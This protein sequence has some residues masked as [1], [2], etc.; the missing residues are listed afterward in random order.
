MTTPSDTQSL[1]LSRAA[2]RPGNLA[3]PLPDGLV[4]AA[5][6]MVVG[7]M[8]AR[9]WLDEVEA[10]LRRGEPMWRET[11]DGHGTTLIATEA[12]LEAI[13]IEPMVANAVANV[14]KAKPK[15][16]PASD[17]ANT[18]KPVVIRAGT[19]QARIIAMLQ[20]P[21]GASIAEIV[22]ATG[23]LAH[24][25]RGSISGALKKKLGLPITAE[26]VEGRGTVYGVRT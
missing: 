25:V 10:K 20:R 19:K 17:N 23:W 9:G 22:A 4:G 2:T 7:K 14:R 1:I 26:K 16:E 11:G 12:G 8:I 6:K 15:P 5:A 18:A 24:T 21:E 13:G 3:L